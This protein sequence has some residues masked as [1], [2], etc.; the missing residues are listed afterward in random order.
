M[1]LPFQ[2][3]F[4]LWLLIATAAISCLVAILACRR[5]E[6]AGAKPMAMLML[7]N[8]ILAVFYALAT[9]AFLLR[10]ITSF[11]FWERLVTWLG[12]VW[13]FNLFWL[14]LK[15]LSPRA[16][17][18]NWPLALAIALSLL[19]APVVIS[20]DRS[21][22]TVGLTL[23]SGLTPLGLFL[24]LLPQLFALGLVIYLPLRERLSIKSSPKNQFWILAPPL[25][26]MILTA[27]WHGVSVP[28]TGWSVFFVASQLLN[29][30]TSVWLLVAILR[31]GLLAHLPYHQSIV[32]QRMPAAGLVL[33]NQQQILALNPVAE[34]LFQIR[35]SG[36]GE[37]LV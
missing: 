1:T 3:Y 11:L 25:W 10:N 12:A 26:T 16:E 14:T 8:A 23:N 20:W 13:I 24:Y 34:Q 18:F 35:S 7:T 32:F 27:V 6:A 31:F 17:N 19:A 5:H 9:E 28:P 36:E 37:T 15:L 21:W 22:V 33:D 30:L 29:Q 2:Q 4:F